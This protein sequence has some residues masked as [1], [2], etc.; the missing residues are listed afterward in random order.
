MK[1]ICKI[2]FFCLSLIVYA[3]SSDCQLQE[4]SNVVNDEITKMT[5]I[6]PNWNIEE[7]YSR[8]SITTGSYPTAPNPVWVTGDSI[9]IYPDEGDQLSFRIPQGGSK[10]CIFDG[11]GWAMKSSSS[12]TAYSPFNRIYYYKEKDALPISMLG[13]KQKGNDNSEHLGAYDI[14]I[15]KG[16]K[17]VQGSLD[18]QFERKVALVRMELK[19]PKAATW[20]SVSLES[21]ALFTTE[22]SMDLSLTTPTIETKKTANTMTLTFSEV[23]TTSD[24]LNII[25][26]MMLL[27]VNLTGKTLAVKL[28][29]NEGNV[30]TANASIVNNKTNF[31]AN[32]ARW[33][34]ADF[35]F[36]YLTFSAS[37]VQT[38]KMSQS[39]STLEYSVNNMEW[40]QLGTNTVTFGGDY[41]NL[42]I[43]GKSSTG[44]SVGYYNY[45]DYSH[46][47]FGNT[48]V[49]VSCSG[50]IRTLIDY[51]N[52]KNVNTANARFC[53]L[54]ENCSNLI[55]APELPATELATCCYYGMFYGC[56]K[57]VNAPVLPTKTLANYCYSNMFQLCALVTAPELPA[58]TLAA[59]CY[60]DMFKGCKSLV[61]TPELPATTLADACYSGM[62]SHCTSLVNAPELPATTLEWLCYEYMFWGCTK[63]M[64]APSLPST[65]LYSGCYTG[66]FKG[67]TSLVNAPQ[68]PATTLTSNCYESMFEECTSLVISPILPA[69]VVEKDSYDRIF[70]GCSSLN[71]ITMLATTNLSS[72]TDSWVYGVAKKGTFKKSSQLSS[73]TVYNYAPSG[74]TIKDYVSD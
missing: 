39:V 71:D 43:R 51:D 69:R 26:Y 57:L 6:L 2:F 67:C 7:G 62:F 46:F 33:I 45:T 60:K 74:W 50:D 29:D 38:L 8:T 66:M 31:T 48:N 63:L 10:T 1:N 30:Y 53:N 54:F 21:D 55:S 73:N 3:C 49:N 61:N 24:N 17:P 18:F 52:Y 23:K 20:V 25:A 64:D 35:T 12:Y 34:Q 4:L 14:Q 42:Q 5:A 59:S 27:P 40:N 72:N 28:A 68:L 16:D 13:Q 15:A 36:P 58:T 11:G 32:G 37:E 47:I 22:A 9:G 70:Y 65:I 44:T 56:T 41:G 19:A